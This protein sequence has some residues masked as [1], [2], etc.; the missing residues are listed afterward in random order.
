MHKTVHYDPTVSQVTT[1]SMRIAFLQRLFGRIIASGSGREASARC[2]FESC[3]SRAEKHKLKLAIRVADFFN[4]CWV[5][6]WRSRSLLPIVRRFSRSLEREY[7]ESFGSPYVD[8]AQLAE[9]QTLALPAE[10]EPLVTLPRNHRAW[11]YVLERGCT[12]RD[13]WRWSLGWCSSG[14]HGGRIVFPSFD[15]NG[16]LN[17]WVARASGR[18]LPKYTNPP[19]P[20]SAIIFNEMSLDFTRP[21][22]V[23]EGPFDA[24]KCGDNAVPLLGSSLDESH[25][26]FDALVRN[27]ST[28]IIMLDADARRKAL[29]IAERLAEYDMRVLLAR[30]DPDPGAMTHDSCSTAIANAA[31]YTWELTLRSKMEIALS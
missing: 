27:G 26:I 25:I 31:P 5:C 22:I 29:R 17:F 24:L 3:P 30:A 23:C 8:D 16:E 1:I 12:E 10:F 13:A 6:G 9:A 11:R 7:I 19:V 18:W 2:P 14:P 20:A 15:Q 28:V 4:H 21:V